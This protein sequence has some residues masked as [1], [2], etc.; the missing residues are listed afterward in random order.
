MNFFSIDSPLAAGINKLVH[1]LY[2]GMLWFLCSIPIITMGAATAALYEVLLKLAKNQ[3]GY[4]GKSFFRAFRANMKQGVQAFIPI[5]LAE[6]IYAINI[7]YYGVMGGGQF[8]LQTVIFVVLFL[9]TLTLSVYVF[10]VMAKFENTLKEHFL[11]A[12]ALIFRNFG[13][14][15]VIMVIQVLMLFL[16]WFFVYFPVVFIMG[17]AGYIQAVIFNYIFERM[18]DGGIIVE[19]K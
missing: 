18:I 9:L 7:F 17:I 10:A 2:V 13:W 1:M 4:I 15:V 12:F 5:L 16:I 11:M 14:S 6:I 19:K 8:K 3:E